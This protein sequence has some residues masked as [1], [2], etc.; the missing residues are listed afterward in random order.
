MPL[1]AESHQFRLWANE[2]YTAKNSLTLLYRATP[3]QRHAY[4][5]SSPLQNTLK[6]ESAKRC[7][8][9]HR[10][11]LCGSHRRTPGCVLLRRMQHNTKSRPSIA[12]KH[13]PHPTRVHT[14]AYAVPQSA[15]CV[16]GT[17]HHRHARVRRARANTS[18]QHEPTARRSKRNASINRSAEPKIAVTKV[19]IRSNQNHTALVRHNRYPRR[20]LIRRQPLLTPPP[21][22]L[23]LHTAMHD[24]LDLILLRRLR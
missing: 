20:L 10:F 12:K 21:H 14:D 1:V 5:S 15:G 16:R 4:L 11:A 6:P 9:L 7:N 8:S 13:L 24:N 2:N 23:L 17:H 19:R 22:R 3:L 18:K